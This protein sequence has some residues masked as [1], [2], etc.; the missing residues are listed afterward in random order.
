MRDPARIL[1]VSNPARVWPILVITLRC[2]YISVHVFWAIEFRKYDNTFWPCLVR[3][4]NTML[5]NFIKI[6][7][8]VN[9]AWSKYYLCMYWC[10]I[11]HYRYTLPSKCQNNLYVLVSY[12]VLSGTLYP[13]N[14][15]I[16]SLDCSVYDPINIPQLP[17]L[18]LS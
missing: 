9:D 12:R 3:V 10:L 2:T 11:V 15:R 6:Y 14:V 7:S 5:K 8:I 4:I 13:Q 16:L 1:R 18:A 17:S